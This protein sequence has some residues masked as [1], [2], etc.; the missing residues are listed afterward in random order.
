MIDSSIRTGLEQAGDLLKKRG[1][2]T[3]NRL[4]QRLLEA[5]LEHEP[6]LKVALDNWKSGWNGFKQARSELA[7]Q[8]VS[9]FEQK[10]LSHEI[11]NDVGRAAAREGIAGRLR[12]EE[13]YSSRV[14]EISNERARL[15]RYNRQI[16]ETVSNGPKQEI[17][18][19]KNAYEFVLQQ[20]SHEERMRP[21]EDAYKSLIVSAQAAE[22]FL[23]SL[24]LIGRPQGQCRLCPGRPNS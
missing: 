15:V 22:D 19:A 16:S 2:D 12:R 1:L 21:V 3:T 11:A 17:E 13:P 23:E 14:E 24:V 18:A 5:L 6:Q 8:A 4:S 10:K 7:R 9:L 20:I